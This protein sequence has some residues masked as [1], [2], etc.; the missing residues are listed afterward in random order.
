LFKEGKI[1]TEFGDDYL[2]RDKLTVDDV[3]SEKV[4]IEF[5]GTPS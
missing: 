5:I 3:I 4:K 1:D 2:K